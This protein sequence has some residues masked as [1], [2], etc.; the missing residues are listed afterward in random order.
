MSHLTTGR[1]RHACAA[2][3]VSLGLAATPA[4]AAGTVQAPP[5]AAGHAAAAWVDD[6]AISQA[7]LRREMDRLL[8]VGGFHNVSAEKWSKVREQALDNLVNEEL[9]Y[10]EGLRRGL[11]WD[12]DWVEQTF[13]ATRERYAA[14]SETYEALAEPATRERLLEELRR[15][16]VIARLMQAG[17]LEIEVGPQE[18]VKYYDRE[19]ARFRSPK[20][21]HVRELSI[22]VEPGSPKAVWDDAKNEAQAAR[23]RIVEG[24]PM[25]ELARDPDEN[26][27]GARLVRE[28]RLDAASA[29]PGL[30]P[31]LDLGAGETSPALFTLRGVSVVRVERV[32]PARELAF[33]EVKTVVDSEL[34]GHKHAE[35]LASLTQALRAKATVRRDEPAG[36]AR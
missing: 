15:A 25:E 33:E 29:D 11:G 16:Q 2:V 13:A 24:E 21:L 26:G 9:F 22:P 6:V 36:T 28:R 23:K 4:V 1:W 20:I 32:T 18:A 14:E 5:A 19:R 10:R 27:N 7:S 35:W 17:R 30:K 8:P 3:A 12:E 31:A 34:L